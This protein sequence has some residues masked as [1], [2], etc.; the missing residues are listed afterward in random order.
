MGSYPFLSKIYDKFEVYAETAIGSYSD[1][2]EELKDYNEWMANAE[3]FLDKWGPLV[4]DIL[5]GPGLPFKLIEF[6]K[7]IVEL[8]ERERKRWDGNPCRYRMVMRGVCNARLDMD[9]LDVII[10]VSEIPKEEDV[11][12]YKEKFLKAAKTLCRKPKGL[13]GF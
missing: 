3:K 10:A 12:V 11:E 6:S 13:L 2:D 1:K 4:K 5:E 9:R 8:D 7:D